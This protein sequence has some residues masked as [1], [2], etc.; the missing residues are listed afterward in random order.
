MQT[1]DQIIRDEEFQRELE[2]F[3]DKPRP[4]AWWQIYFPLIVGLLSLLVI[5]ILLVAL[6]VGNAS[7]WADISIVFMGLP[8]FVLAL[9]VLAT[10]AGFTYVVYRFRS[11][12]WEPLLRV[13]QILSQTNVTVSKVSDST[14]RPFIV[15][16]GLWAG[17]GGVGEGI[18]NMFVTKE[19]LDN[20]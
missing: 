19:G 17:I 16:R 18:R 15:V 6:G 20:E 5:T 8:V 12:L 9:L 2:A 3:R 7:V 13:Q 14:T 1:E 4:E 10:L 11:V